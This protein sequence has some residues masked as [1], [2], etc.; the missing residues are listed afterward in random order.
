MKVVDSIVSASLSRVPIIRDVS[1]GEKVD[2]V[3]G[4]IY[5]WGPDDA[6]VIGDIS[7][8]DIGL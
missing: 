1:L 8:R 6:D 5:D 3:A 4:S 2:N 7:A